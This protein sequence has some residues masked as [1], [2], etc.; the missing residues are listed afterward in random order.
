MSQVTPS[1]QGT[2]NPPPEMTHRCTNIQSP[3]SP[4]PS[5]RAAAATLKSCSQF[6]FSPLHLTRAATATP[7]TCTQS[8]VSSPH[9]LGPVGSTPNPCYHHLGTMHN[10]K[11]VPS[12]SRYANT[13]SPFSRLLGQDLKFPG[14]SPK[15]NKHEIT[16]QH[17][18]QQKPYI[19]VQLPAIFIN[20]IAPECLE[21][22]TSREHITHLPSI[23]LPTRIL[24][25]QSLMANL[26]APT[27]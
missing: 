22:L 3:F 7:N 25:H 27:P 11:L 19:R 5:S 15:I 12:Q 14:H 16:K 8:P 26:I 6:P 24:L 4:S 13:R 21:Y 9:R 10:D 1:C 23:C 20:H 18:G 17:K 2:L